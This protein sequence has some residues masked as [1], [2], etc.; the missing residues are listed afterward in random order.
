MLRVKD[1]IHAREVECASANDRL[2]LGLASS[3]RSLPAL[4]FIYRCDMR[5]GD[6]LPVK[7]AAHQ[8]RK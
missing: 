6:K 4:L 2:D 5:R 8:R 1:L 3:C 7:L